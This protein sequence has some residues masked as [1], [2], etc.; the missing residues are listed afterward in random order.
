MVICKEIH[1]SGV[2]AVMSPSVN[3]RFDTP[4]HLFKCMSIELP[5]RLTVAN[6]FHAVKPAL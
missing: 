4:S 3:L 6:H 1:R 5:T 2:A